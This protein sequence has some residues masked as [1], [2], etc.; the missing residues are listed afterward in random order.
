MIVREIETNPELIDDFDWFNDYADTRNW[1]YDCSLSDLVEKLDAGFKPWLARW[2]AK[3]AMKAKVDPDDL[4]CPHCV[5]K[6]TAGY[7]GGSDWHLECQ[8]NPNI[9]GATI[10]FWIKAYDKNGKRVFGEPETQ[11][12]IRRLNMRH[13]PIT[14]TDGESKKTD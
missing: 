14:E 3:Y 12:A 5:A 10:S 9:C 11:E 4:K 6:M 1:A 13:K 2:R 8:N 7:V